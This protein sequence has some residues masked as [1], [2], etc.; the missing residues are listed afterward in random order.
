M[1]SQQ[2]DIYLNYLS[3]SLERY[4]LFVQGKTLPNFNTRI[5]VFL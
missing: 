1:K 2:F 5:N 3:F 4:I